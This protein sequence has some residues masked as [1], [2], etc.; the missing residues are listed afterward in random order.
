MTGDYI[1][2]EFENYKSFG[3]GLTG[4]AEIKPANIIIGRN[5]SGKS[6]LLDIVEWACEP[7]SLPRH[8]WHDG[9]APR[10]QLHTVL[11]EEHV[12]RVFQRNTSEGPIRGS[13]W[14]AG[15]VLV[16]VRID[17][18][19]NDNGSTRLANLHGAI[20]KKFLY[21]GNKIDGYYEKLGSNVSNPFIGKLFRRLSAERD[22]IPESTSAQLA[23]GKNG[24]GLTNT[25]SEILN[26]FEHPTKLVSEAVLAA[27]N[28]IFAPDSYFEAISVQQYSDGL[29][30][31][32][33][34]E[35]EKGPIALSHSGSGLK[36]ILLVIGFFVLLPYIERKDLSRFIFAFEELENNLHP[37]LQRRLMQYVIENA[38]KEKTLVFLTTHSNVVIDMFSH[39]REAQIIHVSHSDGSS[40]A[41]RTQTYVE[42]RG[43]LDDLDVRASDL[44]QSNVVV[45]VEGP[46]DRLYLNRWIELFTEGRLVEGTHYQ[47]IYYGGRLLAHLSAADPSIDANEV[48]KI[49]RVNKNAILLIDSDKKEETSGINATKQRLVSEMQSFGGIAWVTAGRE[50]EN[51]LPLS[52]IQ[53]RIS[54]AQLPLGQFED[55]AEYLDRLEPGAGKKF[56]RNKVLFAESVLPELTRE[57]LRGTLDLSER[58]AEAIS[59]IK[60]WNGLAIS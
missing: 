28:E 18:D 17:A 7:R 12:A 3:A 16:G 47:C 22:V 24:L 11:T 56:E 43:V 53:A 14:N 39:D 33:L 48:V 45:W 40:R 4:F 19:F 57:S 37:A 23:L 44:L 51:Y 52:A 36:T 30:E 1:G 31:V 21:Q 32:F 59:K 42:N 26:R 58:L 25:I 35:R 20:D 10:V 34:T 41:R 27:L 5:N 6:A 15:K 38:R 8:L 49:L 55:I 54:T 2:L 29:W 46:S 60:G 9:K 13:H 50:I